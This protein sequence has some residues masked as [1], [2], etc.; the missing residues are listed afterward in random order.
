MYLV[1]CW[2]SLWC[3]GHGEAH[4][5][6]AGEGEERHDGGEG[7]VMLEVDWK[8]GAALHVAEHQQGNERH[9]GDDQQGEEARVFAGLRERGGKVQVRQGADDRNIR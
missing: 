3:I 4:K 6:A 1:S 5:V 2:H 8:V 7:G 9:P